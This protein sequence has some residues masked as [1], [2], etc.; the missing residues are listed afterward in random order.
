MG[1][2]GYIELGWGQ[3]KLN[4]ATDVMGC[5]LGT[6]AMTPDG[7]VFRYAKAG[8]AITG[9]GYL[10]QTPITAANH[11]MDLA[12]QAAV[13]IGATSIPVT[14]GAAAAAKDLYK[15]GY[16]WINDGAG[17]GQ[18]F[19]IASHA[20]VASAG[21]LTAILAEGEKVKVAL[22][23]ATSLAGLKLNPYNGILLY[24]TT[25]DGIAT[26]VATVAVTNAYYTWLQTWGDAAVLVNGTIVLGKAIAPGVTTSGSVDTYPITLSTGTPDT[27]VPGDTMPIGWVNN[28]IAVTTDYAHVF[29]T[30]AP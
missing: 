9:A 4:S 12:V 18:I 26:G 8:E 22:T 10:C 7:R 13:A 27:Y 24:N 1:F 11:D 15:D 3:E 6:R 28:P 25:L 20:V 17:E 14:L 5:P 23:T 29:L 19:R 30:I 2:P 16:I 21:T